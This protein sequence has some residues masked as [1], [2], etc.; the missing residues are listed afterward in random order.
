[1]KVKFLINAEGFEAGEI[2]FLDDKKSKELLDKKIVV[3]AEGEN[4]SKPK[5]NKSQK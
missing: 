1:M 4:D 3:L 5:K 2:V